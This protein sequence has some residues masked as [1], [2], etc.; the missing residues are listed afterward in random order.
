MKP[1]QSVLVIGSG[2]AGLLN[3]HLARA[4]G[5]SKILAVDL[6]P[7]RLEAAKKFGADEAVKSSEDIGAL[8]REMNKGR[9]ADLVFVCTGAIDAIL[10]AMDLVERGGVVLLFAPT[11]PDLKVSISVNDIFFR[12]DITL[13]TSYG[14][15]PYDSMIALKLIQDRVINVRDMITHRLP[16]Q[17][18]GRGFQIVQ[19]AT[20]SLKVIIEPQR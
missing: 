14:A 11:D 8:L 1:G 5:A 18:T 4:T 10:Q 3:I 9:L 13:T 6:I 2:I 16:L 15:S 17:E 7:S 20:D 19:K 12:N